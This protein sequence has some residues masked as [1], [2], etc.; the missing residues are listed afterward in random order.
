MLEQER[1]ELL[2]SF[3]EIEPLSREQFLKVKETLTR[4]GLPSKSTG[5]NILWQTCHVLHKKGRYYIVHFKQ[6]FLLDGKSETTDFSYEDEDRLE[7]IVNIL[8]NWGL[9]KSMVELDHEVESN[10]V[11]VSH[12]DRH[13]YKLKAKY[14]LG[15]KDEFYHDRRKANQKE[16]SI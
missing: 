11:I 12:K 9:V 1:Q 16:T 15:N 14:T 6:M 7:W 5:E 4:I 13:K 10:A 3:I 8:E 2:E